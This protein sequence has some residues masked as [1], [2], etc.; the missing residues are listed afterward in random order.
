MVL[1]DVTRVKRLEE[2]RKDF[3]AN[4]SHELRTPL[5]SIK[6]FVET[7]YHG[8][9]CLPPDVQK[10]LEIISKKT[11]RLCSIVDDLL[12][13]LLLKENMSSRKSNWNLQS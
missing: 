7:I 13:C 12:N 11:D 4:V 1:H 2:V 10:F 8:D 6:G 3:V 9:Y 5:T